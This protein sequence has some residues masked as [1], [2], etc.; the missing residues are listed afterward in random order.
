MQQK[1]LALILFMLALVIAGAFYGLKVKE[2]KYIAATVLANQGSC[3]LNGTC[4]YESRSWLWYILGWSASAFLLAWSIYAY[5]FDVSQQQFAKY[6][7]KVS[8]SLEEAQKIVTQ[9][10]TFNAFLSSFGEDEQKVLSAIKEQDGI[11]QS[12]LRYRTGLSKATL[13]I[14]LKKFEQKN[15]IHREVSGKTNKVYWKKKY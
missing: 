2:D 8:S 12:T 9:K 11:L 15:F 3:F 10:D 13:S 1:N 14:M 5:F 7:E 4:L 6:Q